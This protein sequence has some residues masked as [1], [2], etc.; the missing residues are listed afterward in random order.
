MHS[1]A[2][3][4]M[5]QPRELVARAAE[6]GFDVIA[7]SDHD[8]VAGVYEAQEEGR[9]LGVRVISA[10]ELSC[11]AQKEIHLLGYGFDIGNKPLLAFCSERRKQREKRTG[12]MIENLAQ[13][14]M[15]VSIERVREI[16]C[17]VMGRP[18]I[19]RVLLEEG[20]VK[21]VSEAFD[22]FLASGK[23]AYVPKENVRVGEAVRLIVQAGGVAVLAHPME[24]KMGEMAL[25]ALVHEW[26]GQ[27]LM[28]I[29]VWHPSAAN[30]HAA[31]LHALARRE[32]M[33]VTGG[34]DYHGETVRKTDIGEGLE[35]W[36][37]AEAD[38]A[39]LL[40]AIRMSRR[41]M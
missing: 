16:S 34:S 15:P 21:S 5:L 11:G 27:G 14:G 32:Q 17:G 36:R 33:L 30:N 20:Y 13:M 2:S 39:A 6:R 26:K 1:T 10:V 18:H 41:N 25:E 19:A 35:R 38:V 31:F 40:D 29:E 23:P 37:Q 24:L 4:G 9:R 12:K 28:G 7:L 8:S 3:D 22:R